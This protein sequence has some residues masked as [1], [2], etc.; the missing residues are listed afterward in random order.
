M[1]FSIRSRFLTNYFIWIPFRSSTPILP[2]YIYFTK[3]LPSGQGPNMHHSSVFILMPPNPFSIMNTRF[4]SVSTPPTRRSH[5]RFAF[6]HS[7]TGI[8]GV[9]RSY[10]ASRS[11]G[12]VFPLRSDPIHCPIHW[13]LPNCHLSVLRHWAFW[14]RPKHSTRF[15]DRKFFKTRRIIS[16]LTFEHAFRRSAT[17][18][19]PEVLPI[20]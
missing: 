19:G 13:V 17:L 15:S 4:P 7:P 20:A 2:F 11:T 6:G 12:F 3:P 1:N 10:R 18:K 9:S 8:P 14:P 5:H 16:T